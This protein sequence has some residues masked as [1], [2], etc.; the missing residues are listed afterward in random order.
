VD[1]FASELIELPTRHNFALWL[2]AAESYR[3]WARSALGDTA[4]GIPWIEQ[5]IRDYRTPVRYWACHGIWEK[6]L[7]PYI[8]R[9]VPLKLLRQSRRRKHLLKDLS[10]AI[11]ALNYTASR[12]VSGSIG[13]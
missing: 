3:G 1:R 9:I 13:C 4:E 11:S 6:R 2:A 12:C 8:W 7:K 5:G 10:M